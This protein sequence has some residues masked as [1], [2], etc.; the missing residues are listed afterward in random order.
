MAL[1]SACFNYSEVWLTTV[2]PHSFVHSINLGIISHDPS[3]TQIMVKTDKLKTSHFLSLM[4]RLLQGRVQGPGTRRREVLPSLG[5]QGL[6][7]QPRDSASSRLTLSVASLAG[8]SVSQ[9]CPEKQNQSDIHQI[10]RHVWAWQWALAH[11]V[12]EVEK[13]HGLQSTGCRTGKA[14]GVR[15]SGTTG[16]NPGIRWPENQDL[17]YLKTGRDGHT[18][19]RRDKENSLFLDLFV[20]FGPPTTW[21]MP[22][23]VT[24]SIKIKC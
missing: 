19:S 21:M 14:S 15:E 2:Q 22:T 13:S 9:G 17:W 18:S 7:L 24:R 6:W 5:S 20:T 12:L 10:Y 8:S 11:V 1:E 23:R 16:V 4:K 3:R